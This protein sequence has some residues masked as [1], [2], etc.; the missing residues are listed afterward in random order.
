MRSIAFIEQT[1]VDKIKEWT[2][3]VVLFNGAKG[4]QGEK[5]TSTPNV[6]R[7]FLPI[8]MT[9]ATNE[10][11]PKLF[12]HIVVQIVRGHHDFKAGQVDVCMFIGCWDD[13]DDRSGYQDV[14]NLIEVLKTSLYTER[15]IADEFPLSGPLDW[16]LG[17]KS[18]LYPVFPGTLTVVLDVETPSSRFDAMLHGG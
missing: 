14:I 6:Y 17:E 7:G 18:D 13:E 3:D 9:G 11:L 1:V 4:F 5:L 15:H 12:P 8:P 16:E 2:K 10:S